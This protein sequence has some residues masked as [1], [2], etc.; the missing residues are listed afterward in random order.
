MMLNQRTL[1]H[2]IECLNAS[3]RPSLNTFGIVRWVA[4]QRIA[5]IYLRFKQGLREDQHDKRD[6]I[7]HCH[8]C[9]L[10]REYLTRQAMSY[11]AVVISVWLMF[12]RQQVSLRP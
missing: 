4:K 11:T 1:S 10:L 9:W 5:G 2:E 6:V 12:Y 7:T 8:S 3:K